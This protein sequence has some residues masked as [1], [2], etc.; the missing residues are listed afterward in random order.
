MPLWSTRTKT[1]SRRLYIVQQ[2]DPTATRGSTGSVS[3]E[4]E[5]YTAR[6]HA[7]KAPCLVLS[8]FLLFSDLL[9]MC[10]SCYCFAYSLS[11]AMGPIC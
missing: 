9:A 1:A 3:T 2:P 4:V 10:V 5:I 6:G 8:L 7:D 11:H